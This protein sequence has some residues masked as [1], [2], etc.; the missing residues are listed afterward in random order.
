M[1]SQEIE[2]MAQTKWNWI[3]IQYIGLLKRFG[4]WGQPPPCP[5]C[6]CLEEKEYRV[7][8]REMTTSLGPPA[9]FDDRSLRSLLVAWCRLLIVT[10]RDATGRRLLVVYSCGQRHS[11]ADFFRPW[12]WTQWYLTR[13]ENRWR[14][15]TWSVVHA[16]QNRSVVGVFT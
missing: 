15:R 4:E 12:S 6:L 16:E 2:N 3:G 5:C 13:M 11:L 9:E 10:W 7:N 14:G 1:S 8:G